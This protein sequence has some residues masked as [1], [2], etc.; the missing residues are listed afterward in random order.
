MKKNA[1]LP[2]QE[3][4]KR[5]NLEK[6]AYLL[7]FMIFSFPWVKLFTSLHFKG[8]Q[9]WGWVEKCYG[10]NVGISPR[11]SYV[12]THSKVVVWRGGALGGGQVMRL[13][14]SWVGLAP[15]DLKEIGCPF[16]HVEDTAR[17]LCLWSRELS[18]NTES[19]GTLIFLAS[20]PMNNK[21]PLFTNYPIK[22]I[23]L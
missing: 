5:D 17:R 2:N 14:P 4:A 3:R 6:T 21:F 23:L 18:P 7:S 15:L 11:N 9:N 16:Y 20:R 8:S 22:G 19:S 10:L 1:K 12:K 13:E